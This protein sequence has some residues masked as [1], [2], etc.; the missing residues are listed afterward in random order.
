MAYTPSVLA[1]AIYPDKAAAE[2]DFNA[3]W[4]LHHEGELDHVAAAVVVKTADGDLK[5]DRHDTTAKHLAWGGAVLGGALAVVAAPIALVPLSVIAVDGGVLAGAGGI[6][7]H[8]HKNIPK[9]D[10]REMSDLLE[11]GEAGLVIVAVDKKGT[12]VEPVL[13]HATKKFVRQIDQSDFEAAY[14]HA[15]EEVSSS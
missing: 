3:V 1:V 5:M 14:N 11:S 10:A 6:I 15:L 9:R 2:R 4:G 13:Q 12:D 7:G 8:F